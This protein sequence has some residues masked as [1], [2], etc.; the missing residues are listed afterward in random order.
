MKLPF[1]GDVRQDIDAETVVRVRGALEGYWLQ[2]GPGAMVAVSHVL[3]LLNPK[4]MWSL[5]PGSGSGAVQPGQTPAGPPPE[6]TDPMTGC[7]PVSAPEAQ[8]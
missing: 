2:A 4:G 6:G 3:D 8:P 5:D 7:L 1:S